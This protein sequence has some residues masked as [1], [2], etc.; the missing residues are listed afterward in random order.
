[1][2]CSAGTYVRALAR[3]LG[4]RLGV[5]A[6]LTALRRVR[7]GGFRLD[8]ARTVDQLAAGFE[9]MSMATAALAEFPGRRLDAEEARLVRHGGS[10]P[11]QGSAAGPVA[12]IGPAGDLVALLIERAGRARPVCVLG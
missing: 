10:L 9:P 2:V 5:G 4:E 1:V 3:D 12:A 7:S 6:H 11:A 8:Q